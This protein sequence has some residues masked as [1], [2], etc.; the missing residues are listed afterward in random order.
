MR[1]EK[2]DAR[3]APSFSKSLVEQGEEILFEQD[4]VDHRLKFMRSARQNDMRHFVTENVKI[5]MQEESGNTTAGLMSMQQRVMNIRKNL[6]CMTNARR[7]LASM[8]ARMN[9]IQGLASDDSE[10][11]GGSTR[12]GD[13]KNARGDE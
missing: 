2:L 9:G 3:W 1:N 5:R 13:S 10:A 7:E 12:F 4:V 11:A 8:K 6:T